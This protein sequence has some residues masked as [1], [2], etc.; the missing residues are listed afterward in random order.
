MITVRELYEE[1]IRYEEKTLA[2]YILHL[3]QEGKVTLDDDADS[4][5][6]TKADHQKV[7]QMIEQNQLG[8]SDIK[9]F[10][11]KYE[12]EL[13]AFVFAVNEEEAIQF[14]RNTFKRHPYNCHQQ[15]M[16]F[17]MTRGRET[18]TFRDIKKEHEKFPALAGVYERGRYKWASSTKKFSSHRRSKSR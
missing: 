15:L 11:L 14:F 10:S 2:H 8:F 3:L 12:E 7:A 17:P 18:V 1:S 5:D 16:D 13:F 9:I 4:L 6:F